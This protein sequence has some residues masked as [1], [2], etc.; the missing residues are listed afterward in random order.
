MTEIDNETLDK[1]VD[2][3]ISVVISSFQGWIDTICKSSNIESVKITYDL[4]P[5][6]DGNY[7]FKVFIKNK[8][9]ND[10][11]IRSN[12]INT[13]I[14]SLNVFLDSQFGSDFSKFL[15][16]DD[17][18]YSIITGFDL[19]Y[20]ITYTPMHDN[21]N[22]TGSDKITIETMDELYSRNEDGWD[23]IPVDR[24]FNNI[25]LY[26]DSINDDEKRNITKKIIENTRYVSFT[27]LKNTLIQ[28]IEKLPEKI[29]LYFPLSLQYKIGSEHWL[30]VL[31]WPYLKSK[32]YKIITS[33]QEIDNTYQIV[34]V[35]DAMYSGQ[36]MINAIDFLVQDY[37]YYDADSESVYFDQIQREITKNKILNTS[38]IALLGYAS[39]VSIYRITEYSKT[40]NIQV[41]IAV[42][43]NNIL[44]TIFPYL[45]NYEDYDKDERK[46]LIFNM[47]DYLRENFNALDTNVPLY[48][49]H[50]I[51]GQ[52]SSFPSIYEVLIEE[53]K[54]PSRYKIGELKRIMEE[55][56]IQ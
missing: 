50:K 5:Y 42:D 9:F 39:D 40:S 12:A 55:L 31:L 47:I 13:I 45:I 32:V 37:N 54:Q 35:D 7:F 10:F 41:S 29:N 18:I 26:L 52:H 43:N 24:S 27:E 14:Q 11:I 1:I 8:Q 44:K 30:T 15:Y 19:N 2:E 33:Y 53:D 16:L 34:L 51:A 23:M 48:F 3:R 6:D 22:I 28:Q 21:K 4:D 17:P 56:K 36:N 38:I 46:E 49:D 20:K 25:S